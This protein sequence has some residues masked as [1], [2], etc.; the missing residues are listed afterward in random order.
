MTAQDLNERLPG[1]AKKSVFGDHRLPVY[2][3]N[4]LESGSSYLYTDTFF[5]VLSLT[6]VFSLFIPRM[7]YL[8]TKQLEAYIAKRI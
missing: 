8:Y 6:G 7:R 5:P 4:C 1:N 2:P 3:S